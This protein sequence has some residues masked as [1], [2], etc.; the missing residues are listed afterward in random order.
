MGGALVWIAGGLFFVFF[1]ALGQGFN[2]PSA[3]VVAASL[4]VMVLSAVGFLKVY[5][6]SARRRRAHDAELA[7]THARQLASLLKRIDDP[8]FEHH[9]GS[10]LKVLEGVGAVA[11]FGVSGLFLVNGGGG[12]DVSVV[13]GWLSI[14]IASLAG[15]AIVPGIGRDALVMSA[16]GFAT[17]HTRTV[18][19][20][21]VIDVSFLEITTKGNRTGFSLSISLG[22][23]PRTVFRP[24]SIF[25]YSPAKRVTLPV[26]FGRSA[27]HRD[28]DFPL[29]CAFCAR[30]QPGSLNFLVHLPEAYRNKLLARLDSAQWL[31]ALNG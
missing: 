7:R 15:L 26:Q 25:R 20:N 31:K 2:A 28:I 13:F 10:A 5:R 29:F 17:P 22:E 11:L 4:A 8:S 19:W 23:L 21:R 9:V 3:E 14:A 30:A 1:V 18:P 24:W 16:E 12:S 6:R 27:A